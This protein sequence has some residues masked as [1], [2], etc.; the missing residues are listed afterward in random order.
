MASVSLS[1]VTKY[2]GNV[3]V[4]ENL[5]LDIDDGEFVVLV[6]PSG[7]GKTTILRMIAGLEEVTAGDILIGSRNVN[8][9]PPKDR[10]VAM[11]FQSYALYP[12]MRVRGNLSFALQQRRLPKV[13]IDDR[14]EKAAKLLNITELLERRP[15]ELSGGQRQR[16]AMGRALVREPQLYL[17][18]EPLSNL[19]AQ[20][21]TQM[22]TEI[23]KL[24]QEDG[25]T[26]VYVTHDQV[27]AMT[28]A[29][30]IV[31]LRDGEVQQIGTPHELYF[32]P[33][34]MFVAGFIGSPGM[35]FI[36]ARLV[37]DDGL[38]V[39]VGVA[40]LRIPVRFGETCIR[41]RDQDVVFGIRPESLRPSVESADA[42]S[43]PVIVVEPQGAE[44][45]T[46]VDVG[47]VEVVARCVAGS[48]P[49]T[50]TIAPFSFDMTRMHLFDRNTGKALLQ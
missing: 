3:R 37:D 2:Y 38:F 29:H 19:D 43:L 18:D 50:G 23:K 39:D 12:H 44:A 28:L 15:R 41:L 24:H 6:G 14:V 25:R 5:N 20:L 4:T 35:N 17:F 40:K 31:V 49:I 42:V 22:R 30:R 27:E 11:V 36:P 10:D 34:S 46:I 33:Q 13:V 21:R 7:C 1:G 16:V 32:Q 48:E 45:M 47:G 9:L 8:D 26:V